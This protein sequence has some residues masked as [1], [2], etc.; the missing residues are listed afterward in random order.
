MQRWEYQTLSIIIDKE[1]RAYWMG[2]N[3]G[4][5][6]PLEK[7]LDQMGTEGWEL[8]G[9]T[10]INNRGTTNGVTYYLKRAI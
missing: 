6:G 1:N 4:E 9:V 2:T 7:Q 3:D 5:K 8:I 10:T